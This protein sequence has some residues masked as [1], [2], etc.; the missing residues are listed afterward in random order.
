MA[1]RN[2]P[3][4]GSAFQRCTLA[5]EGD[6]GASHV[7]LVLFDV[8]RAEELKERGQERKTSAGESG[9]DLPNR[10]A[11][12]SNMVVNKDFA[13][14]VSFVFGGVSKGYAPKAA[15]TLAF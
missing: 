10:V 4:R 13:T 3:L 8:P 9:I 6:A 7:G 15:R 12:S 14:M 5:A 11:M 1:A 2:L